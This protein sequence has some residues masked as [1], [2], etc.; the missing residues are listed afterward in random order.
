MGPFEFGTA[1][2]FN[3]SPYD[4]TGGSAYTPP[5]PPAP[6]PNLLLEDGFKILCENGDALA[7]EG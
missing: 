3:G 5:P 6:L 2:Y 7:L 1:I 4:T